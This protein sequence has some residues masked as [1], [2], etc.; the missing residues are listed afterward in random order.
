MSDYVPRRWVNDYGNNYSND[1]GLGE[2][3]TG[4][5]TTGG[6]DFHP[7]NFIYQQFPERFSQPHF[8][9]MT[10][11]PYIFEETTVST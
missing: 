3:S 7:G 2:T 4:D 1:M 8:S 11:V 6:G 5:F 9:T 10:D